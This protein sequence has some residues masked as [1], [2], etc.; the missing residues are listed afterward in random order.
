MTPSIEQSS[1]NFN[2]YAEYVAGGAYA[3]VGVAAVLAVSLFVKRT[4]SNKVEQEGD[5]LVKEVSSFAP[6]ATDVESKSGAPK[7]VK[8][9]T[10]PQ[11]SVDIAGLKNLAG[12]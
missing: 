9:T 1:S 12:D 6:T 3:L 4:M 5:D 8:L 10:L 7:R 2:A 11:R